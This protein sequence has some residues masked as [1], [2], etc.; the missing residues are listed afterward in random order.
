MTKL[1]SVEQWNERHP[2]GSDV[3]VRLDSGKDLQTRT[4]SRA[5][6]LSGHTPVIWLEGVRGCYILERVRP[7]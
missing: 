4:R 5:E 1:Q 6:I 3:I 2:V 7:A